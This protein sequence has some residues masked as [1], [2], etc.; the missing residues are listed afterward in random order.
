MAGRRSAGQAADPLGDLAG[1]LREAVERLRLVRRGVAEHDGAALA[2]HAVAHR[3]HGAR[4]QHDVLLGQAVLAVLLAVELAAD[5]ARG[6]QLGR[7]QLAA[8]ALA[9]AVRP[10]VVGEAQGQPGAGDRA[11]ALHE[12]DVGGRRAVAAGG[13][14]AGGGGGGRGGGAARPARRILPHPAATSATP[15]VTAI[16]PAQRSRPTGSPRT[17]APAATASRMLVSRTA[18][19]GAAAARCR[20]ASTSA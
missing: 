3:R 16:A 10:A 15:A 2:A 18:A 8:L 20:A 6:D 14:R 19:T 11:G 7:R 12:E 9:V 17:S 1:E 4:L 13:E 5:L